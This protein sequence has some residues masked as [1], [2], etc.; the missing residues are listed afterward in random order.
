MKDLGKAMTD[1]HRSRRTPGWGAKQAR[2]IRNSRCDP[3]NR[4]KYSMDALLSGSQHRE[5]PALRGEL[6]DGGI[7]KIGQG[8]KARNASML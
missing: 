6:C 8:M 7:E 2:L 5:G 1:I 4:F 3:Q